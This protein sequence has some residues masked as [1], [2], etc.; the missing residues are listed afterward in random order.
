MERF[1]TRV[2]E[3]RQ[4]RITQDNFPV[5]TRSLVLESSAEVRPMNVSKGHLRTSL[6]YRKDLRPAQ[7]LT[8]SA[9]EVLGATIPQAPQQPEEK[10]PSPVSIPA[11]PP[12]PLAF[13]SAEKTPHE[14]TS[15]LGESGDNTPSSI[16]HSQWP[17]PSLNPIVVVKISQGKNVTT[18]NTG[19]SLDV[20]STSVTARSTELLE[21]RQSQSALPLRIAKATTAPFGALFRGKKVKET[22]QPGV[23]FL[24]EPSRT[25]T[26][27]HFLA[28]RFQQK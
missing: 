9:L 17:P 2:K 3:I 8:E 23:R 12:L 6:K 24:R 4:A 7:P 16:T 10:A 13:E 11:P 25:P 27:N 18:S 28:G 26:P 15:Q 20:D 21:H 22:A 1:L 5:Y 14:N 19:L